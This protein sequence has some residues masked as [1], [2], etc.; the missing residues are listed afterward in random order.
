[1]YQRQGELTEIDPAY[2]LYPTERKRIE[3]KDEIELR[4][5]KQES[6]LDLIK[7]LNKS[8]SGHLVN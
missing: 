1:V 5:S 7:S 4:N 2:Y 3:P 8:V 6:D